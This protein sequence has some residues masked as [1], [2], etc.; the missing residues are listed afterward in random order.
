MLINHC[1]L[2]I[3]SGQCHPCQSL[4]YQLMPVTLK[5]ISQAFLLSPRPLYKRHLH[6]QVQTKFVSLLSSSI[7]FQNMVKLAIQTKISTFPCSSPPCPVT[8][9]LGVCFLRHFHRPSFLLSCCFCPWKLAFSPT[10]S[11]EGYA[12]T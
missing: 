11:K 5:F 4:S 2:Y 6:Q 10:I 8:T 12:H 1:F 9:F 7:L 3:P